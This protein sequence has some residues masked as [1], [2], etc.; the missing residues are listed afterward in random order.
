MK[1]SPWQLY[2]A[3]VEAAIYCL[4]TLDLK[5]LWDFTEWLNTDFMCQTIRIKRICVLGNYVLIRSR[6]ITDG[7]VFSFLFERAPK[8]NWDSFLFGFKITV[9]SALC[10]LPRLKHRKKYVV[11]EFL[12]NAWERQ[13]LRKNL[14]GKQEMMR[15]PASSLIGT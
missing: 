6:G 7:S 11:L 1:G 9:F 13:R 8:T 12:T 4:C 3:W 2:L 10:I 14:K 15:T 5:I